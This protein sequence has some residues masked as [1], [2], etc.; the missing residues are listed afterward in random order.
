MANFTW[1][2]PR[3]PDFGQANSLFEASQ[4]QAMGALNAVAKGVT[5]YQTALTKKNTDAILNSL[6]SA[7]TPEEFAVAQQSAN[8]MALKLHG[9]YD[10]Q[11]VRGFM[12]TR[13]Q[14]LM[15][16]STALTAYN[17]SN[18]AEADKPA[19]MALYRDYAKGNTAGMNASLDQMKS[20]T[21]VAQ[22]A[23]IIASE[24]A[25]ALEQSNT[26]RSANQQATNAA[27]SNTI[28]LSELELR[29]QQLE[30]EKEKARAKAST[31]SNNPWYTTDGTRIVPSVSSSKLT[32]GLATGLA[33]TQQLFKAN[34]ALMPK[35]LSEDQQKLI[36]A[37]I[38]VEAGG[39]PKAIS[40]AGA[41]GLMQMMPIAQR[42]VLN[43]HGVDAY[44][45]NESNVKAGYLQLQRYI[46]MYDGD[47]D[48]V[49][50]ANNMGEGRLN[51]VIKDHPNDWRSYLPEETKGHI[52]KVASVYSELSNP[53]AMVPANQVNIP[54]AKLDPM[55]REFNS[56]WNQAKLASNAAMKNPT[57]ALQ[58]K[59]AMSQWRSGDQVTLSGVVFGGDTILDAIVMPDSNSWSSN[60]NFY[61]L[62]RKVPAFNKLTD[63]Q[64]LSVLKDADAANARQSSGF[65]LDYSSDDMKNVIAQK[66]AAYLAT[67]NELATHKRDQLWQAL[68]D[69]AKGLALESGQDPNVIT[70]EFLVRAVGGSKAVKAFA[71]L[72]SKRNE[73]QNAAVAGAQGKINRIQQDSNPFNSYTPPVDPVVST[74]TPQVVNTSP[75]V[76]SPRPVQP[77]V[78]VVRPIEQIQQPTTVINPTVPL[79]GNGVKSREDFLKFVA[80]Q[81]AQEATYAR[82]QAAKQGAEATR[83]AKLQAQRDADRR[84]RLAKLDAEAKAQE[85]AARQYAESRRKQTPKPAS[86][87]T[88][89]NSSIVDPTKFMFR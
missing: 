47:M 65:G 21:T 26:D 20:P 48:K 37:N 8:D 4:N 85:L 25:K 31:A 1:N 46:K 64:Q 53:N 69:K 43:R 41:K 60:E 10:Q 11:A 75:T 74:A 71:D 30:I 68:T 52:A 55:I 34:P 59:A 42:D 38:A 66:A 2:A 73:L 83:I 15:E 9:D 16:R 57:R 87:T 79:V 81:R 62:A 84:M 13:P 89:L 54:A 58:D 51:K 18:L 23:G 86:T 45:S 28:A 63:R 17:N 5:D 29:R 80:N 88:V 35:G 49:F 50:A 77:M 33:N 3:V 76:A 12:D 70:N 36:I 19:V 32:G 72:T 27:N 61:Q 82:E 24:R 67:T 44:S 14:A 39:D 7:K 40:P 56:A 22:G 78:P 6:Y